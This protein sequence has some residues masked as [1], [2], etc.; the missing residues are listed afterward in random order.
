[1]SRPN[2]PPHNAQPPAHMGTIDLTVQGSVLT[3]TMPPS[4]F[5]NGHRVPVQFGLQQIPV[6][7]GPVRLL[8]NAQWMRT[9][10]QAEMQLD[11][12]PGQRVPVFYAPPWHQ[13]TTGSIGHVPQRRKGGIAAIL[14]VV[15]IVLFI[16][17]LAAFGILL[18]L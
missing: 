14:I 12:Q 10:G 1:M 3:A 6:P 8:I 5:V 11:L 4:V 7:A 13:F 18:A 17:A 16:L 9:Y 2:V 15:G